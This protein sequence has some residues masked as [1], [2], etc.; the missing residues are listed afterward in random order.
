MLLS[1][2]R[3][4]DLGISESIDTD[5]IN[6][7]YKT[8]ITAANDNID[9]VKEFTIGYLMAIY[10]LYGKD[11]CRVPVEYLNY[12]FGSCSKDFSYRD[13][14]KALSEF[15]SRYSVTAWM[16]G[17]EDWCLDYLLIQKE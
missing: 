10:K 6:Y 15:H 9:V 11:V 7:T 14:R 5:F 3:R 2:K 1:N 8:L 4:K 13:F 16:Y 17:T 12:V